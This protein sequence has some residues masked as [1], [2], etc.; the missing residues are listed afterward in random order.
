MG[1]KALSAAETL[2]EATG[3]HGQLSPEDFITER[4]DMLHEMFP[5]AALM[6]GAKQLITH[7]KAAGVPICVAT[8]S[9][10]RHFDLK[11]SRHG[12]FFEL[13]DHVVTGDAVVHGKPDPEIFQ[14]AA[15]RWDPAPQPGACLV[16]EDAPSGVAAAAAAGMRCV[17]VPD[18]RLD[19]ADPARAQASEVL[20]SL[21]DVQLEAYGL[22]AMTR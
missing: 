8:S 14:A 9:H 6:P 20:A 1:L 13:F 17:M 11:T 10:R 12:E 18:P 15:A 2:I 16:F 19:A 22:P 3:L 5:Q 7:L 4:E 21:D